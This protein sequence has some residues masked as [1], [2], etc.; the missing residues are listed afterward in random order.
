ML[1]Y[2]VVLHPKTCAE[3]VADMTDVQ[4]DLLKYMKRLHTLFHNVIAIGHSQLLK[5]N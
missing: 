1:Q 3:I 4:Q 5:E 2:R